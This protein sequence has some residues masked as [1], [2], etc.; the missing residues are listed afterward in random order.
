MIL[1]HCGGGAG[2]WS[3]F[4]SIYNLS[5]LNLGGLSLALKNFLF[6]LCKHWNFVF[7]P[8]DT[9][10]IESYYFLLIKNKVYKNV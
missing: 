3:E 5:Q 1:A 10:Y 9:G 6:K 2:G 7:N 8:Y 4:N